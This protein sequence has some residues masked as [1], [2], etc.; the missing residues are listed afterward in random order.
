MKRIAI[1]AFLAAVAAPAGAQCVLEYQRADNSFAAPGRPDGNLGVEKLTLQPGEKKVFITDW[2]YE[3]Q[4]NDGRN[5]YGSHVRRLRNAGQHPVHVVM[6][7]GMGGAASPVVGGIIKSVVGDRLVGEVK[8]G[9]S[10]NN[11]RADLVE[12]TCASAEARAATPAPAN[13]HAQQTAPDAIVLTWDRVPN[14]REYRVYVDP[15][16]A[17]HLAGKPA[18]VGA[19][20]NRFVIPV[21]RTMTNVTFNASI[22]AVGP[23]NA[24]S[25]RARFNPVFVAAVPGGAGGPGPGGG[26]PVITGGATGS[27]TT[28][29][30]AGQQC[31]AGQFVTGFT[32]SGTLICASPR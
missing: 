25:P 3:K 30:P 17:A 21:P 12:A 32:A 10:D 23:D 24:V 28:P 4:R 29:G 20:G 9:E 22:E 16:P 11:L 18:I 13:L 6:R 7:G 14:A 27:P 15:P 19:S 26:G 8:P 2:K 1:M 5:Y 31:P